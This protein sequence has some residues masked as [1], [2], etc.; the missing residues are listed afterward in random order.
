MALLA[1]ASAVPSA[2]LA[3]AVFR[4][5][6]WA[7]LLCFT[8]YSERLRIC[9]MF[10]GM[11]SPKLE[12]CEEAFTAAFQ[13][14]SDTEI[15]E[16]T[17]HTSS[18]SWGRCRG[19]AGEAQRVRLRDRQRETVRGERLKDHENNRDLGTERHRQGKTAGQRLREGRMESQRGEDGDSERGRM[20][21]QRERKMETRKDGDSGVWRVREG[22]MD[23]REDGESGGWRLIERGGWRVRR[24]WRLERE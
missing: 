18:V 19:R 1:L 2:L 20:E 5:P 24:G 7:C 16:E 11:R 12:E 22:R 4:V 23:T 10:V 8:T 15:S 14:L 13:G 3:L 21:T 17:I 6:A 9:Q